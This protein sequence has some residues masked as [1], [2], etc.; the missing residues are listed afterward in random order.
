M[1]KLNIIIGPMYSGK[2][3][4][5]LSR[6]CRYKVAGKKCLLVKFNKDDRYDKD[7]IVTHNL[8]SQDAISCTDLCEIDN[9]INDYD[10]ILIDEVQ[11]Y[12]DSHIYCDKWAYQNKIVEASGLNGDYLRKPFEQISLLIPLS[13][14][15]THLTAVDKDDGNDAPFTARLSDKSEQTLIGGNETYK[16]VNRS[17]YLSHIRSHNL[18]NINSLGK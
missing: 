2:T 14:K 1:G 8:F 7:K 11:F 16:A 3:S 10:V 5:L 13:D 9:L 17:N 15:I 18:E 4:E 6:Y 12:S